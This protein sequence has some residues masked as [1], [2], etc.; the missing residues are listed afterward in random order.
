MA[1]LQRFTTE[2][3]ATEDR[4]RLSGEIGAQSTVVLWLTQRLLNRLI[5]PLGRWLELQREMEVTMRSRAVGLQSHAMQSFAQQAAAAALAP[6]APVQAAMGQS[7]WLVDSL[8]LALGDNG[9][10]LTFKPQAQGAEGVQLTLHTQSLRQWLNIVHD[11]CRK[12]EWPLDSWPDWLAGA[13]PDAV[14][15][16]MH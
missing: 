3:I 14:C 2:Y 10:V 6:Q 15:A 12:A 8:D 11:Q 13:S 16:V 7:S 5:A 9:V 4:L 1:E